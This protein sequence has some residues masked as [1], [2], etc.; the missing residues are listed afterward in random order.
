M[1]GYFFS[2][3]G[4]PSTA[5]SR[6][7]Q[8]ERRRLLGRDILFDGDY[9]VTPDGDWQVIEGLDAMRQ[10]IYH[11]LITRPG[12]FKARPEYGVGIYDYVKEAKTPAMLAQLKT[13]IRTNLLRDRRISDVEVTLE[14][15]TGNLPGLKV[16]VTVLIAGE[17][18]NLGAFVFADR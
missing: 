17:R 6:A 1:S 5:P 4:I 9:H 7:G 8:D 18:L 11:R 3:L 13:R 10:A 15:L 16:G 2:L 14:D 12:E